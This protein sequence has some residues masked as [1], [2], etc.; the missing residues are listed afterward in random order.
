MKYKIK[1]MYIPRVLLA[2]YAYSEQ[3]QKLGYIV[4]MTV[5][6]YFKV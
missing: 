2:Q 6:D 1:T 5:W 3:T 4:I